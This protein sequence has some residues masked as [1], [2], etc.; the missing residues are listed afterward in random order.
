M[1][2][3][4]SERAYKNQ[5]MLAEKVKGRLRVDIYCFFSTSKQ[6]LSVPSVALSVAIFMV[7]IA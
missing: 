4:L 2:I 1:H 6:Q 5:G 3:I 7:G